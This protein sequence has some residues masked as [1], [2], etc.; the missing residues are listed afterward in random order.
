MQAI[1][2]SLAKVKGKLQDFGRWVSDKYRNNRKKC[3]GTILGLALL[4]L[5]TGLI[6]GSFKSVDSLS[7]GASINYTSNT[8]NNDNVFNTGSFLGLNTYY[9]TLPATNFLVSFEPTP[10]T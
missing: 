10:T 9:Q 6:V 8:I 2:D 5:L 7:Q 4:I 1:K 3:R